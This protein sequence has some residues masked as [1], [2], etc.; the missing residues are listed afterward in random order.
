MGWLDSAVY[1]RQSNPTRDR[2]S[3]CCSSL[4]FE[5][6]VIM[7]NPIKY[8]LMALALGAACCLQTATAHAQ[9]TNFTYQGQLLSGGAPANGIYNLTFTLFNTNASGVA[10]AGPVTNS[11]TGVTNGLFTVAISF[12]AGVFTGTNYWLEVAVETNGGTNFSTLAPRQAVLPTPY[13]IY[14]GSANSVNGT[15]SAEQLTG[16]ANANFF[17]GPSGNTTTTGS[18]N[19]ADGETALQNNTSGNNNTADGS[20]ALVANKTGSGNTAGGHSALGANQFG[21]FN[22]AYGYGALANNGTGSN[23]IALGY[24]AGFNNN[25]GSSNIDIGNQGLSADNN[26]IR[27]GDGQ[28]QTY[29]AGV[30]NGNG[31]G[32]TNVNALTLAGGT[33]IGAGSANVISASGTTDSFI[34]GG[35]TNNIL[36]NS[37]Y[38]VI[39][40]GQDNIIQPNAGWSFIGGGQGNVTYS[41]WSFI[42]GGDSNLVGYGTRGSTI[43]GGSGNT[44]SGNYATVP[45]GYQNLASGSNSFAAGEEAQAVHSGAFVWSDGEGTPF[46][47]TAN[48]QFSVRANGGVRFITGGAGVTV[49]GLPIT[50][51]N[52]LAYGS[53][54]MQAGT[55]ANLKATNNVN[56]TS[57]LA[58]DLKSGTTTTIEGGA[59]V[60]LSAPGASVD[61]I[62]GG[63]TLSGTLLDFESPVNMSG[64]V[65]MP[66]PV[67]A[68]SLTA[69][70]ILVNS[71]ATGG[72]TSASSALEVYGSGTGG[73]L[74][75]NARALKVLS[76]ASFGAAIS[77]DATGISG[78]QDWDF[79]STGGSAS[80]GQGKLVLRCD[81]MNTEP[82]TLTTN[83]V[84]IGTT[85]PQQALS[86]VG[87]INLDQAGQNIGNVNSNSLT[88]GSGSGEGIASKRTSGGTQYDLEFYTSFNNRMIILNNGNVG[89]GAL[90]PGAMLQVGTATCNGSS[91]LNTS[92]RNLKED[93]AAI[94]PGAVLEKVAALPITKWKY[95]V[96]ADG[97]EHLGPM[98][99]DF[100]AAF[101][102]NGADDKHI[103]TVDEEGV[104]LAAIQG[105][106]QKVEAR[107]AEIQTLRQQNDAL[108]E[109]LA[110]L[111]ATVKGM[112][113]RR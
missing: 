64:L 55:D 7:K 24:Q 1:S 12:G 46:V 76:P 63:V 67:S 66:G 37:F 100:H 27:I 21:S 93:L 83:E 38:S 48:N 33:A 81:S 18:A 25:T 92:D 19:T 102:L 97:M 13:A 72:P 98:A 68:G 107:D 58:M 11:A 45:G 47:S 43:G 52:L 49:D 30:I 16:D 84:G 79:F 8:L 31:G 50:S 54:T 82:M 99:Q 34:G 62:G 17:A 4:N 80:E 42:G 26:I 88:F 14:A 44:N 3:P 9:G 73:G 65:T 57:G 113:A 6:G 95:K 2:F 77:C 104:A 41:G 39:V 15:V 32:V 87:G 91:W 110:E 108:A 90:V 56:I 103:A 112:A 69:S 5:K 105:L 20:G 36:F 28:T 96:E 75:A 40:G 70:S 109:R 101:G 85:S 89:I 29:L 23:N 71:S 74:A 61:L 59:E 111:E 10:I 22:T 78:G 51:S 94:N 86:V 60:K 106:N 53:L 35:G